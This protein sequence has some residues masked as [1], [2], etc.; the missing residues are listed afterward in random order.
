M[1]YEMLLG[2]SPFKDDIIKIANQEIQPELP[3]LTFPPEAVLSP[4]ARSFLTQM[5]T[6]DPCQRMTIQQTLKHEFITKHIGGDEEG[7][8]SVGAQ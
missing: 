3:E 2:K 8:P 1:A 4:E 6:K 5:L 7:C